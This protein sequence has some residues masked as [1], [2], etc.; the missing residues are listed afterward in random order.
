MMSAICAQGAGI[1]ITSALRI[2]SGPPIF[3]Y[4][5]LM[6]ILPAHL[7]KSVTPLLLALAVNQAY[8]IEIISLGIGD[9]GAAGLA[10]AG[11][12]LPGTAGA[13]AA[14]LLLEL[15][16]GQRL[17]LTVRGGQGGRGGD[18]G[19]KDA[20]AAPG[21]GGNG[22]NGALAGGTTMA[23][24]D[25]GPAWAQSV[26]FGGNG[27][28]GG[29]AGGPDG[30]PNGADYDPPF[31]QGGVAGNGGAAVSTARAT[32]SGAGSAEAYALAVGGN[33]GS[34][35]SYAGQGGQG[36]DASATAYGQS[37]TG[38][39]RVR[40]E[41]IGGASGQRDMF[42][43]SVGA[44]GVAVTLSNAVAGRTQ[45]D[46]VLEQRA[47]GGAAGNGAAGS[48]QGGAAGSRLV[49]IDD[50]ASSL[51][52]SVAAQG[53]KAG[54]RLYDNAEQFVSVGGTAIAELGLVSNRAGAALNGSVTATGG[55]GGYDSFLVGGGG[56]N[57]SAIGQLTGTASVTG[58]VTA[59]GGDGFVDDSGMHWRGFGGNAY[60]ALDL[61]AGGLATGSASAV[62]GLGSRGY[63]SQPEGTADAVL[64]LIGSGARGSANAE[65][66]DAASS[67]A[68]SSTG[69]LGVDVR[70]DAISRSPGQADA[71]VTVAA[72]TG[73][74]AAGTSAVRAIANAASGDAARSAAVS[75]TVDVRASG[76]VDGASTARSGNAYNNQPSGDSS[77]G[78]ALAFA[79]GISSG[80]HS[81][82][83]SAGAAGGSTAGGWE[84]PGAAAQATAYG[85][86]G[87]G[88]VTVLA[89]AQAGR[90]KLNYGAE[91][92]YGIGIAVA[93][94]INTAYQGAGKAEARAL[95]G[96]MSALAQA[97][98]VDR[99]GGALRVTA[100]TTGTTGYGA[101]LTGRA[102][103]S[104][105]AVA[106]NYL[107][108][109]AYT[110]AA[111][112]DGVAAVSHVGAEPELSALDGMGTGAIGT[113]AGAGTQT[114]GASYA[115]PDQTTW[116]GASGQFEF[117]A[118]GGGHLLIDLVSASFV[119]SFSMLE[120][121]ITNHG[122]ALFSQAFLSADDA[123]LFF[124]GR[125]LDLGVLGDGL[126]DVTVTSRYGY[127]N[128]SAFAFSYLVGTGAAL[129]AVPEPATWLMLMLGMGVVM[130]G[131][132]ARRQA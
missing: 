117:T 102:E 9:D 63:Y 2:A 59:L 49:V 13:N 125:V 101:F 32:A 98:G 127:D 83:L 50:D 74:A 132:R 119:N 28:D 29:V 54:N 20:V 109:S 18:G 60:S 71:T 77:S 114:L 37:E 94:A 27:G 121:T 131:A 56:G 108:P 116:L 64:T 96:D 67:I 1:E 5:P 12:G 19:L 92:S 103:I 30:W 120:L 16:L 24:A 68:V 85:Q 25:A 23:V 110:P 93:R 65:G 15:T 126:Q 61:V 17:D 100:A 11:P 47:V 34:T 78:S 6:K 118:M 55:A 35:F 33:G 95:G 104:G 112:P 88:P 58:I 40:A 72:G 7:K 69:A 42:P 10:G 62:G 3:F 82:N 105:Q 81:V 75:A 76:N 52:A 73:P 31:G 14:D 46:L 111:L 66:S 22:G 86:S 57:A 80:H 99:L 107:S 48:I 79:S 36:G 91:D 8:A 97:Q 44:G 39:V 106:T 113:L 123:A 130:L 4:A 122:V 43:S 70:A 26:V 90:G 129:A 45:G 84:A 38:T 89:Q 128:A 51:T 87:N 115:V 41:T 53:G 124:N 21:N